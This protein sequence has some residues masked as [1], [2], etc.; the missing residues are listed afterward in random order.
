MKNI[1]IGL[2][3]GPSR[4]S[5]NPKRA[6]QAVKLLLPRA[7]RKSFRA[8]VATAFTGAGPVHGAQRST[9]WL[10][11]DAGIDRL[12]MLLTL[13]FWVVTHVWALIVV[14]AELRAARAERA[15]KAGAKPGEE[16]Q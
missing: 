10:W 7:P 16:Q 13:L 6:M 4:I 12:L 5:F 1:V 15:R 2:P 3:L 14:W 8:L 9:A 11:T